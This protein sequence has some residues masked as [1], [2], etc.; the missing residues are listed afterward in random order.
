MSFQ[1]VKIAQ[2]EKS[3]R[4]AEEQAGSIVYVRELRTDIR[5]AWRFRVYIPDTSDL[6]L[7]VGLYFGGDNRSSNFKSCITESLEAGQYV[8]TFYLEDLS[9]GSQV[10]PDHARGVYVSYNKSFESGVGGSSTYLGCYDPLFN[11]IYTG[12]YRETKRKSK[13]GPGELQNADP[14]GELLSFNPTN[15]TVL[16]L[17]FFPESAQERYRSNNGNKVGAAIWI[18][19]QKGVQAKHKSSR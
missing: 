19:P 18:G 14:H 11:T 12:K 1:H 13:L 9:Q 8:V 7:H 3:L 16:P 4:V 6:M 5:E 10:R 15:S 2:L 17:V